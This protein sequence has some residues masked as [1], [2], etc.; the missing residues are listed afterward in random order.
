EKVSLDTEFF[1]NMET[2][3]GTLRPFAF[4]SERG[5]IIPSVLAEPKGQAPSGVVIRV[6]PDG[7]VFTVGSRATENLVKAG[8]AVLAVD[9]RGTG[10]TAGHVPSETSPQEGFILN[11]SIF[12]GRHISMMRAWDIKAAVRCIGSVKGYE[13]LPVALWGDGPAAMWALFAF[14]L[15]RRIRRL[16]AGDLLLTFRSSQ[17]FAQ[18]DSVFPPGILEGADVADILAASADR[19]V[20]LVRGR[21]S[22]GA[23][24][25][26][27][28]VREALAPAFNAAEILG[29]EVPR[30]ASGGFEETGKAIERFLLSS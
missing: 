11:R 7:K 6:H 4:R 10:E 27:R 2:S 21:L 17:G 5:I 28:E 18:D 20:L 13:K 23:V 14:A 25:K 22:S 19:G 3:W 26:K 30:I 15:E 16:V 24:A 1:P 12:L 29:T 8:A 9:L